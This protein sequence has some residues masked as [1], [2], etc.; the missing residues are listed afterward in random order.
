MTEPPKDTRAMGRGKLA[1]EVLSRKSPK[2]YMF[3]WNGVA[4]DRNTYIEM[5]DPYETYE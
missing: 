1:K 4:L 3:D 5:P 2:F